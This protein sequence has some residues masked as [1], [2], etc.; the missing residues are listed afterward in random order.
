MSGRMAF[1]R[2]DV[3]EECIASII[4]V[5]R[6]AELGMSAHVL[7][8]F[9]TANIVPSLP[10]LVVMMEAIGSFETSVLTRATQWKD[11]DFAVYLI[12]TFKL[13][14]IKLCEH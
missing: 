7:R 2:T 13:Y 14:S 5:P 8:L 6:V 9:I 4:R 11:T 10:I 3:L 1:V 12:T